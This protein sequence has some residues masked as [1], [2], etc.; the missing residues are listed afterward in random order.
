MYE[1]NLKTIHMC[2]SDIAKIPQYV[3]EK[4]HKLNPEYRIKFYGNK[5]CY[6]F[7]KKYF[8]SKL[9]DYFNSIPDGHIKADLWRPCILYIMGGVYADI[10]VE[11]LVPL[12]DYITDD[13]DFLTCIS[14]THHTMNPVII[15]ARPKNKI[16]YHT[17]N[18]LYNKRH[19][20]YDY[21]TYS[22][23]PIMYR[24]IN[25]LYKTNHT[26]NI[27]NEGIY[28]I[29]NE[30]CK[31]IKEVDYSYAIYNNKRLFNNNLSSYYDHKFN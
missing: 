21:W 14:S 11:P 1:S 22:I 25:N 19:K 15:Y 6:E 8:S 13:I 10:D 17:L 12:R 2:Y 7:L 26:D 18:Q 5:E 28:I 27:T 3:Y 24:V 23:C 9:A 16:L 29:N 20:P 30:K 4:W 31:L